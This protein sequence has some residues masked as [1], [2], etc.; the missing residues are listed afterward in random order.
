MDDLPLAAF[1]SID[2]R[3]AVI[4]D[5]FL[6]IGNQ[7]GFDT[8]GLSKN[9]RFLFIIDNG[10]DSNRHSIIRRVRWTLQPNQPDIARP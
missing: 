8:E 1:E 10:N 9:C 2:I 3:D 5:D 7:D 6:S 4:N